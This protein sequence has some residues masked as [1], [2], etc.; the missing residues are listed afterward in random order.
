MTEF[1]LCSS[2]FKDQGLMLDAWQIGV[3]NDSPC[4]NCARSDGKKLDKAL[5]QRLAYRFFVRGSFQRMDYGGAPVIQFNEYQFGRGVKNFDGSLNDDARLI[6]ESIRIGFFPYGPRLWMVGEV[7]PLKCL[8]DPFKRSDVIRRIVKEYP[9]RTLS[10]EDTFFRLRRNPK[11]PSNHIEY[12]SPPSPLVGRGRLDTAQ[13]PALY[14]S[15][16]LEVCLH[17]CRV[18]VEDELFVA[19]LSPSRNVTLL[20]LTELIEEEVTEFDSLDMAVHM[21]FL[22]GEYSYEM[23]REIAAAAYQAKFDGIV[24]PSY[25]SHVFTG[26]MPFETAYGLSVRRFPSAKR[27]TRSQTIPNLALFGRPI[28]EGIITVRCLNRIVLN[29][30]SYDIVFGPVP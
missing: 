2:C 1:M 29:R 3:E 26:S 30:V 16:D 11:M 15:Q 10:Q 19:T 6:E 23:S 5:I 27:Y 20:D 24:Y 17:E 4:R 21:L 14:C 22:A 18:S 7:E 13:L 12:D 9:K 28:A 8:Q 25:F